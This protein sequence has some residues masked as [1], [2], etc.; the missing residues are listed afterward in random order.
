VR[1]LLLTGKGGVGKTT[2]AAATAVHAARCGVKTLVASTD[3]AHSLGDALGVPVGSEPSEVVPGLFAQQ[4]D[5][6]ARGERS[7]RAVQ[8]YLIGVLDVL[9]VDPV[10]AEELTVLPGAEEVLALLEV[11][12]Q[13]REGPW[14]LVV[15]DCAPTAETLRLLALPEAVNRYVERLLPVERRVARALAAGAS[16]RGPLPVPRDTVVEA[17]ERLHAELAG[18][19]EVLTDPSTS[20]RLVLTPEAVVVSEARRTW[21]SLAL[22]GYRVDGVVANRVVPDGGSDGWRTGWARAQQ[23]RLADVDASFAP[24]PVTRLAYAAAEPVGVEAL[25]AL[26]ADLH[27][28]AGAAAAEALLA[29]PDGDPPLRVERSGPEFV[30][31]LDLPLARRDELDLGRRGDDLLVTVGGA[32]RVIALPSAL[33][34]CRVVGAH[35]RDGRLRVRFEPDPDLWRPL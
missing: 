32:R 28:P 20:V 7:W 13:V 25:A 26:G 35:L 30:L 6:R 9:G 16:R 3:A 5:A 15:L 29:P 12:D 23:A 1:L 31:A 11:R 27:G 24:V 18:V 4:V 21:T 2:V 34:R 17:A 33:R 14:D 10:A 22:H 19:Q 8:E